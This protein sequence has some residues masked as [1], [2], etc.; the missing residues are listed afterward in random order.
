ML[1]R[2]T[3]HSCYSHVLRPTER[4][5]KYRTC[6]RRHIYFKPI[7]ITYSQ[8]QHDS[9]TYLSNCHHLQLLVQSSSA[10]ASLS[11]IP[12]TTPHSS[13]SANYSYH[14]SQ[15]ARHSSLSESMEELTDL[16]L[17]LITTASLSS[18]TVLQ[19]MNASFPN[20]R[21]FNFDKSVHDTT[22]ITYP[23]AQ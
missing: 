23:S 9:D 12:P 10:V 20:D 18:T 15:T 4:I 3:V 5:T 13:S 8:G 14:Q 1:P 16:F 22:H 6:E 21:V 19:F 11:S 2:R 7:P 17:T